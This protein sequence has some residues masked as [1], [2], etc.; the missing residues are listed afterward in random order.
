MWARMERRE[1]EPDSAGGIGVAWPD[2]VIPGEDR[3]SSAIVCLPISAGP[4]VIDPV[5]GQ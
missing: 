1:R 3:G 2:R 5:L 4:E